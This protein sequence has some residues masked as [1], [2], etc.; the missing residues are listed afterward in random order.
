MK[1]APEMQPTQAEIDAVYRSSLSAFNQLCFRINN[2]GTAFLDNYHIDAITHPLG[3]TME[4][5]IRRLIILV[6]PRSGKTGLVSQAFPTFILG[7]NPSAKVLVTTYSDQYSRIVARGS[8]RIMTDP[9]Y[10]RIFPNTRI[11]DDTQDELTTTA[12]GFRLATSMGGV[13]TGLGADYII[14]DDIAKAGD[15]SSEAARKAV[16]RYYRE[17]LITRLNNKTTGVIIVVMQRLHD[18]DL[19]GFLLAQG[20]WDVLKLPA[21]ATVDEDIPIGLGRVHHR[22]VGDV[23]W[24]GNDSQAVLDELRRTMGTHAFQAQYQQDPML[25]GGNM[26]KADWLSRYR[27]LPPREESQVVFSLDA[28]TKGNPSANYSAL[29]IWYCHGGLNYL[30]EVFRAQ[31]D[32]PGLREV[33]LRFHG[34]YRPDMVLIEDKGNGSA[35]IDDLRRQWEIFAKGITPCGDKEGR[36]AIVLPMFETGRVL[37]PEEAPWLGI[38]ESELLSFPQ[39]KFN[40]QVDSTSQFLGWVRDSE[41]GGGFRVD[42]LL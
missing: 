37:L 5:K 27:C 39:S 38:F 9:S 13:M 34:R 23:L 6:P 24:P 11:M 29:T 12:N 7:H 40:D 32:Y 41:S 19:V 8:R 26:V 4:G 28:A 36:L 42:W 17:T 10:Q 21:I 22:R 18:D 35:L 30:A 25:A 16:Q 15:V 31:L 14:I 3:K 20:G 2:P 1:R 33:M